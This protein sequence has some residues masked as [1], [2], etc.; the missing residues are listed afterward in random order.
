M[1]RF[2]FDFRS[3]LKNV[4]LLVKIHQKSYVILLLF[5]E[6]RISAMYKRS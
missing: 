4:G 6:V 1:L 5:L 2:L 3:R